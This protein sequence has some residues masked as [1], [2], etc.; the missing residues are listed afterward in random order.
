MKKLLSLIYYLGVVFI[1][2]IILWAYTDQYIETA[3]I[4]SIDTLNQFLDRIQSGM[5]SPAR[6]YKRLL[7]L[8]TIIAV[9]YKVFNKM[10]FDRKLGLTLDKRKGDWIITIWQLSINLI[11]WVVVYKMA[12]FFKINTDAI[13]ESSNI[14]MYCVIIG[15]VAKIYL[16]SI[17][18]TESLGVKK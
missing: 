5:D 13:L 10:I 15:V 2:L 8:G 6:D 1:P 12:T 7:F 11:A 9:A 18:R 4:T 3:T 16:T 14:I 17:Y